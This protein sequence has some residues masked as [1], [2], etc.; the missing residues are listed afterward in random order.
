MSQQEQQRQRQQEKQ[1]QREDSQQGSASQQRTADQTTTQ[2]LD[3]AKQKKSDMKREEAKVTE[4]REGA[5]NLRVQWIDVQLPN[6]QSCRFAITTTADN[7][8]EAV[9]EQKTYRRAYQGTSSLQ[10]DIVP[11]AP[12]GT[13]GKVTVRDLTTGETLEQPWTWHIVGSDAALWL[14]QL[15]KRLFSSAP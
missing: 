1:R 11:V 4:G 7:S 5:R 14:W 12:I 3:G 6:A 9:I 10:T 15:L 13:K 2:V 8:I